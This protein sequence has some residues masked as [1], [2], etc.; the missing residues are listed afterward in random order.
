MSIRIE[1]IFDTVEEAT[2]SLR[3]LAEKFSAATSSNTLDN[4]RHAQHIEGASSVEAQADPTPD[5][6][7]GRGRPP[8]NKAAAASPPGDAQLEPSEAT[9]DEAPP[10]QAEPT[11]EQQ[12]HD[13]IKA[14][15]D[16]FLKS[17]DERK[18]AIRKWRDSI[19]LGRMGDLKVEH[20]PAA[21]EL[22]TSME[23]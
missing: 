8:K 21:R 9:P 6:K 23:G 13:V 19:G 20:V 2:E 22:L 4:A 5:V 18:A 14:L 1:L 7:R 3:A 15:T 10:A 11:D 17:N 12:V 16:L